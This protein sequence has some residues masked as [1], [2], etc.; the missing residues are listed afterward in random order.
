[1]ADLLVQ[2]ALFAPFYSLNALFVSCW[3]LPCFFAF[4]SDMECRP[5]KMGLSRLEE[6]Q[7]PV[8]R[9]EEIRRNTKKYRKVSSIV[10]QPVPF[11]F[12]HDNKHISQPLSSYAPTPS[13]HQIAATSQYHFS[14]LSPNTRC[15]LYIPQIIKW[16]TVWYPEPKQ[17]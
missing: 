8:M 15:Q 14:D 6:H 3:G 12:K 17:R 1:M 2:N 16:N 9:S 13:N 7:S 5:E 10:P 11:P 4:D